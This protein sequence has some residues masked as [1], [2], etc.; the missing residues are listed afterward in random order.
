MDPST[1]VTYIALRLEECGRVGFWVRLGRHVR[2]IGVDDAGDATGSTVNVSFERIT[3]VR[4]YL[5]GSGYE[6]LFEEALRRAAW[7]RESGLPTAP[8]F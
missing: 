2:L 8:L 1:D 6:A 5:K 4:I 3:D 7:M